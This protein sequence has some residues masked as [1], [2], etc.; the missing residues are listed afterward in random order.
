MKFCLSFLKLLACIWLVFFIIIFPLSTQGIQLDQSAAIR[1]TMSLTDVARNLRNFNLMTQAS[2]EEVIRLI[3]EGAITDRLALLDQLIQA[4]TDRLLP[5]S[6]TVGL[7]KAVVGF[8]VE[9][10]NEEERAQL[11]KIL[12]QLR[13]SGVITQHV[14]KQLQAD[15]MGNRIGKLDVQLFEQAKRR[16]KIY[17]WLESKQY[18]P[19]LNSLRSTAVLSQE[20]YKRLLKDFKSHNVNDG[21]ELFKY[22]DG[23]TVFARRDNSEAFSDYLQK[24][25]VGI[26]QTLA[27]SGVANLHFENLKLEIVKQT[28]FS[29]YQTEKLLPSR[30][31]IS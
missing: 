14:H 8:D 21:I 7:F 30:S 4:A 24:I 2:Y 26:A 29:N 27:K 28:I 15:L 31:K 5:F 13:E 10:P 25:Y 17:E 18:E 20:G 3:A 22:I 16:M 6:P 12:H 19:L 11:I 1:N 9:E 23:S